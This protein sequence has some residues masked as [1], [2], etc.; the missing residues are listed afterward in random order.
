MFDNLFLFIINRFK[1]RYRRLKSIIKNLLLPLLVVVFAILYLGYYSIKMILLNLEKISGNAHYIVFA[2]CFIMFF[3]TFLSEKSPLKLHPASI[4]IFSGKEISNV[5]RAY[6]VIQF[7]KAFVICFFVAFVLSNLSLNYFA[8]QVFI[9]L[10]YTYVLST[11][12]RYYIYNKGLNYYLFASILF[13]F[14]LLNLQLYLGFY[15]SIIIIF[16]ISIFLV[17]YYFRLLSIHVD[18]NKL[19]VDMALMNRAEYLASG[20]NLNEANA[21][22]REV[23]A[24]KSRGLLLKVARFKNPLLQKNVITFSRINFGS[25]VFILVMYLIFIVVYKFDVFSFVLTMKELNL[26]KPILVFNQTTLVVNII[27]I[28]SEQKNLLIHKSREGLYLT[29]TNSEMVKSFFILGFPL[30]TAITLLAGFIFSVNIMIIACVFVLYSIL[31]FVVLSFDKK[32][33]VSIGDRFVTLSVF[34]ISYLLFFS[35]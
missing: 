20:N 23:T 17:F 2:I 30:I 35:L 18:Y 15:S 26:G 21:F 6:F 33:K 11:I 27:N 34:V 1:A 25:V 32:K 22:R 12:G 10:Y 7:I 14:I 24:K 8:F 9:T 28:I 4:L 13:I 31:L 3:F 19:F 29:Y 5:I 16:I